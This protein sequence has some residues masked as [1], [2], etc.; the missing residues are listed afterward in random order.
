M[1]NAR[2][3]GARP[4]GTGSGRWMRVSLDFIVCSG[5]VGA[6]LMRFS[7][8][9]F[10]VSVSPLIGRAPCGRACVLPVRADEGRR[11]PRQPAARRCAC[12]RPSS[13]A[14][15]RSPRRRCSTRRA[16][17]IARSADSSGHRIPPGE[18]VPSRKGN[19]PAGSTDRAGRDQVA[20]DSWYSAHLTRPCRGESGPSG[21]RPLRGADAGAA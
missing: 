16:P 2:D 13:Q 12:R 10:H 15:T 17:P 8:H 1:A 11:A 21:G 7:I 6:V 14:A 4:G 18:A 19:R 20:R 9:A 3:F 5:E